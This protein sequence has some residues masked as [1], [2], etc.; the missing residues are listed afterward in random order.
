M[1]V[2]VMMLVMLIIRSTEVAC[3][4]G[5][6]IVCGEKNRDEGKFGICEGEGTGWWL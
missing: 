6:K 5:I 2:V 3:V 1:V 4:A